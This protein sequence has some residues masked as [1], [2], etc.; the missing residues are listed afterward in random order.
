MCEVQVFEEVL[1]DASLITLD[2]FMFEAPTVKPT[3]ILHYGIELA[4]FGVRREHLPGAHPQFAQVLDVHG[5]F[6]DRDVMRLNGFG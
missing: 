1:K 4:D 3:M 6:A 5:A 2:Q